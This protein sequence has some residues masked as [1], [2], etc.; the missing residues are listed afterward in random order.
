MQ[1]QKDKMFYRFS[2]YGFL[3]NLRFFEPFILL[4]FRS[5]GLSFLQIGILYSIR[6]LATNLLEIPTG[7]AADAFG[8]RRAMVSAFVSYLISFGMFFFLDDFIFLSGAM[9]IFAFGEAFRTGTHKALILEYL[10]IN[11]IS[12]LKVAY[13]GLTRSASQLGSALNALIAAGLVFYTGSYRMMFLAAMVPYVLD[14]INVA[15]YPAEL[16]GEIP[17]V[18]PAEIWPRLKST[19]EGFFQLF[20]DGGVIRILLNSASFSAFYKSTKDYLQPILAALALSLAIFGKFEGTAR[21]ALVIGLVY[22]G[23]YLLTSLASRRAYIF[24]SRFARKSEAVNLTFLA[25]GLLLV[26]SGTATSLSIPWI[27]VICFILVFVLDNL[28]RPINVGLISDQ[29]SSRVMA[30]GLSAEA[31]LTSILSALLAPLL[32]LLADN[33]G[34]GPG[35]GLIGL[36]MLVMYLFIRVK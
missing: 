13:Y 19:M 6:D 27:G 14:L 32:G 18:K 1:I 9:I 3:K 24:S 33:L 11:Q 35:V 7:I 16:D 10:K 8:R 23:I 22:F 29:I 26:I 15:S 36:L 4:I 5:Y 21:E 17:G 25:G 30:S 34:V 2:F 12:D 20:K 28:R 31:Q